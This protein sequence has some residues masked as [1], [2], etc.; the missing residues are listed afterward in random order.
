VRCDGLTDWMNFSRTARLA[1]RIRRAGATRQRDDEATAAAIP[2]CMRDL[3]AMHARDLPHDR[4]PQPGAGRSGAGRAVKRLEYPFAI[5]RPDARACVLDHDLRTVG[6]GCDTDFS[7]P[8]G[9]R[10]RVFE[11]IADQPTQQQRVTL[12]AHRRAGHFTIEVRRLFGGQSQQFHGLGALQAVGGI[13]P[14][15]EQQFADEC[16]ELEDVALQLGVRRLVGQSIDEQAHARQRRPQFMRTVGQQHLVSAYQLLDALIGEL[17]LNSLLDASNRLERTEAVEL[18]ALAAEEAAHFDREV[19]GTPVSVEGDPLLLR[20][21]IRNLLENA[22][23][24][25]GGATEIRVAPAA[26]GAQVVIED[27]GPGVRPEDRERIF[28]PFFRAPGAASAGAGLGLAIV[29]Q[30]ARVH[31][32]EVAHAPRDGGGSRFIVTLPRR[33]SA[34]DPA[35]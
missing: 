16:V 8:T 19:S 18:L 4:Q 29:R 9:M 32:G 20:R 28:E 30:I 7:G 26:D 25:A 5:L 35:G 14:A 17:L 3:A 33:T 15:V 34:A 23:A 31:G 12:H 22:H 11:Q 13:Q 21:L 2:W 24:H 6:R 10:M 27:A 1:R